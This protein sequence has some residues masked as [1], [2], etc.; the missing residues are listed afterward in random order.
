MD[1][2]QKTEIT[3]YY[4]NM[5]NTYSLE[6]LKDSF[7]FFINRGCNSNNNNVEEYKIHMN[8]LKNCLEY[9]LYKKYN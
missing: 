1:T 8:V 7:E 3:R 5:Y 2:I 9:K 6:E 4:I